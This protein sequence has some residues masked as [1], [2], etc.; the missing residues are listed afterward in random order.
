[1]TA[2]AILV[3]LLAAICYSF[4]AV[5]QHRAARQEVTFSTLDPRLLVRLAHRRLWL[6]GV[7][8][9][10]AGAG[11]HGW[12][13]ALG[14]LALV[15]PLLVGGLILSV[16]LE[17]ALDRRR[18]GRRDL[19]GVVL[20]GSGLAAFVV[21]ADPQPGLSDPADPALIG[22]SIGIGATVALLVLLALRA[23]PPVRATLLGVAAGMGYALAAT[24]AKAVVGRLGEDA[25]GVPLD[26]RLYGFAAIGLVAVVLNQNAF[27]AGT[28]AGPLTGIVLTDPL[29][30]LVIAVTAYQERLALGGPR[31]VL[32]VLALA[33]MVWGVWL[34]SVSWSATTRR[35]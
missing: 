23:P 18:P 17:A 6:G 25:A 32:A 27:Q 24:L 8:A 5:L 12:A 26:W 28:L 4:A 11:F 2:A 20:A 13:L 30:S 19:A 15:Q 7:V 31:T 14:P 22:V 9:D 10:L 34:V 1:V 33:V 16:P 35:A 3:G 29:V 21:L